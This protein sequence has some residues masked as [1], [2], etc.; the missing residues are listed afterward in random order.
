M[1]RVVVPWGPCESAVMNAAYVIKTGAPD[2][3][4]DLHFALERLAVEEQLATPS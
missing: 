1:V 4:E 3:W 2:N